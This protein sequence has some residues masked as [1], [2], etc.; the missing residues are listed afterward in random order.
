VS[1]EAGNASHED[2]KKAGA[3]VLKTGFMPIRYDGV[4]AGSLPCFA[5]L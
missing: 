5:G 4:L 3:W 1:Q 2:T